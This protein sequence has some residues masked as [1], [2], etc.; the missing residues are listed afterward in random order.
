MVVDS[1]QICNAGSPYYC[2]ALYPGSGPGAHT[3]TVTV[4]AGVSLA[5]A[6]LMPPTLPLLPQAAAAAA[7]AAFLPYQQAAAMCPAGPSG[8]PRAP[9]APPRTSRSSAFTVEELLKDKRSASLREEESDVPA[10]VSSLYGPTPLHLPSHPNTHRL[11]P[12]AFPHPPTHIRPSA[13]PKNHS[14]SL[15]LEN[16]RHSPVSSTTTKSTFQSSTVPT[17]TS[18]SPSDSTRASRSSSPKVFPSLSSCTSPS[19]PHRLT[20][21][22]PS[23]ES[24]LIV[25][26]TRSS[27]SLSSSPSFIYSLQNSNTS[28]PQI[29]IKRPSDT[30]IKMITP[31][32]YHLHNSQ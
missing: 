1:K 4:D 31:S 7:A 13:L 21:S 15:P 22:P 20:P 3:P 17:T 5:L 18:V 16:P 11:V 26:P 8:P 30:K 19:L 29:G 14:P 6:S 10:I 24:S 2:A 9:L 23:P 27:S 25:L 28:K 12:L 32:S